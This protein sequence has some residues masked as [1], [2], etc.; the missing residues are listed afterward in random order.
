MVDY[1]I[2]GGTIYNNSACK[3]YMYADLGGYPESEF[4]AEPRTKDDGDMQESDPYW[5]LG[6]SVGGETKA[7]IGLHDDYRIEIDETGIYGWDESESAWINLLTGG[8]DKTRTIKMKLL[9]NNG[10]TFID[11]GILID[12][13]SEGFTMSIKLP[14]N[15]DASNNIKITWTWK[16]NITHTVTK[17]MK[18]WC[19]ATKTDGS[20][21]LAWN[22]QS[23]VD[24]SIGTKTTDYFYTTSY[25]IAAANIEAGDNILML[26][27]LSSSGVQQLIYNAIL[28]YE[29]V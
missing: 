19:A 25:T 4:F 28:T 18:R 7:E 20:E 2:F 29:V 3:A 6:G 21:T 9:P 17:Y 27:R 5:R 24:Y 12:S 23:S 1:Y 14:D 26:I 15:I 11:Y 10:A 16:C 13:G 22:I 8:A